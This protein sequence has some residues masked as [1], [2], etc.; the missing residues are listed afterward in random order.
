MW[1]CFWYTAVGGLGTWQTS[2]AITGNANTTAV[3][4]AKFDWDEDEAIFYNT[5]ISTAAIIGITVGSFM[6]GTLL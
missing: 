5:I 3:F 4:S 1:Y 6:G 2:W